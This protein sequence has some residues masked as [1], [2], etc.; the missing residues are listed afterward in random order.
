VQ[1][2]IAK[3]AGPAPDTRRPQRVEVPVTVE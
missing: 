1:H 2:A 3:R